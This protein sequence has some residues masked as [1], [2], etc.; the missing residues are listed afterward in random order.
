MREIIDTEASVGNDT[1][2]VAYANAKIV[3]L[4]ELRN[5]L[6]NFRFIPDF[7]WGETEIIVK[8]PIDTAEVI[9][10]MLIEM[11]WRPTREVENADDSTDAEVL[12]AASAMFDVADEQMH[13]PTGF[14]Q[15]PDPLADTYRRMARA[16]LTAAREVSGQ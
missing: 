6:F 14:D 3:D 16:A 15:A 13:F 5:D 10:E 7:D 12:A 1:M 11:G 9:V 4:F 8:D 2:E